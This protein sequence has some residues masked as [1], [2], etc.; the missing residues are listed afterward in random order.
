LHSLFEL[1]ERHGRDRVHGGYREFLLD[2]WALPARDAVSYMGTPATAKTL[3]ANPSRPS[4]RLTALE[5]PRA[6]SSANIRTYL[7]F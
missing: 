7:R 2:D 5:E 4:V 1:I 3:M 6:P